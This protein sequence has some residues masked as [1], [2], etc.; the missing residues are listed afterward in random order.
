MSR[1]KC[2]RYSIPHHPDAQACDIAYLLKQAMEKVEVTGDSAKRAAIR[3]GALS[4]RA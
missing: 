1:S 3:D 4:L 2:R